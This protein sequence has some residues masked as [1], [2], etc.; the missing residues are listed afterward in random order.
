ME[1][2]PGDYRRRQLCREILPDTKPAAPRTNRYRVRVRRF[3]RKSSKANS[4]A[5]PA[6]CRRN[7]PV[8]A[9]LQSLPLNQTSQRNVWQPLIIA[10][11]FRLSY[12]AQSIACPDV[13]R[14]L[15]RR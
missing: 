2:R 6:A 10:Q 4:W 14:E 5:T 7:C 15:S 13:A 3:E 1:F 8:A 12:A 9:E 11:L